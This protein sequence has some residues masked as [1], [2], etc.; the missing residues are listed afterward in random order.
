MQFHCLQSVTIYPTNYRYEDGDG[1]HCSK[2]SQRV[3]CK[4]VVLKS[5]HP[6]T[7]HAEISVS[8][9]V[10]IAN[11]FINMSRK[12]SMNLHVVVSLPVMFEND[13]L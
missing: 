13:L 3:L 7:V 4:H 8:L 5:A 9:A 12:S 2:M 11:V 1:P 6:N 10:L